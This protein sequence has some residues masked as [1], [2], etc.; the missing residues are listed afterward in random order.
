M[1]L[2]IFSDADKNV[3]FRKKN[4]AQLSFPWRKKNISAIMFNI[5]F[6]PYFELEGAL[7]RTHKAEP[8]EQNVIQ[9]LFQ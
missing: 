9:T 7:I 3:C 1:Q 4:R 2:S 5:N 8:A 6:N